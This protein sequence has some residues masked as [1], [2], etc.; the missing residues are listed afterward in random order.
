MLYLISYLKLVGLG[1]KCVFI[2]DGCFL[3]GMLG[4]LIGYVLLEVVSG[5]VIVYVENGDK[6][7][8]DIVICEIILVLFDEEFEVCK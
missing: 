6:I 1:E 2:I 3:G 7:I 5:G 4:L 8:I